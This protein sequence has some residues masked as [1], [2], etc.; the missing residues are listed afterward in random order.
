MYMKIAVIHVYFGLLPPWFSLF[1]QSCR[2]NKHLHFFIFSDS[3][4]INFKSDNIQFIHQTYEDFFLLI[5]NKLNINTRFYNPYKLC[6]YKPAFGFLFQEYLKDF[7]YWGYCDN[8]L[9][10]GD[11]YDTLLPLIQSNYDVISTN[12]YFLSGSFCLFR[13]CATTISM[14]KQIHNYKHILSSEKH[15][16]IDEVINMPQNNYR[17]VKNFL[18]FCKFYLQSYRKLTYK[19]SRYAFRFLLKK[20]YV[21]NLTF[22]LTEVVWKLQKKELLTCYF[23]E[24][25]ISDRSLKRKGFKKFF[26]YWDGNKL[27]L[28]NNQTKIFSYHLLDF[29]KNIDG[30]KIPVYHPNKFYVFTETEILQKS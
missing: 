12:E 9:V 2:V 6:D 30:L 28:K 21:S 20:L 15:Y 11:T 27:I 18:K 7:D 24:L 25:M 1:I 16:A 17:N 29:K 8:D 23:N 14:F 3:Q 10:L 26:I 4:T 5:K 19:E 22:D 13:N